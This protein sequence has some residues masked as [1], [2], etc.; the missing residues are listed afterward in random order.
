MYGR[1]FHALFY[2][3]MDIIPTPFCKFHPSSGFYTDFHSFKIIHITFLGFG[4]KQ[5]VT[6]YGRG[7]HALS[8]L[9]MDIVSTPFSIYRKILKLSNSLTFH[10]Y[11]FHESGK[12]WMIFSNFNNKPFRNSNVLK[13]NICN[14]FSHSFCE[15]ELIFLEKF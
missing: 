10:L 4:S 9:S 2:L 6:M 5:S 8:Y 15:V 1:G 12:R 7:F 3:S 14:S 13:Q 11:P